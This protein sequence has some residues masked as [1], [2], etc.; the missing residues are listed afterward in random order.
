[1]S[2]M[3]ARSLAQMSAE[4]AKT[5]GLLRRQIQLGFGITSLFSGLG[6]VVILFGCVNE[7]CGLSPNRGEPTL[8]AGIVVEFV[9]ATALL[10]YRTNL[11]ELM[12]ASDRLSDRWQILIAFENAAALPRKKKEA[13]MVKLIFVLAQEYSQNQRRHNRRA[14]IAASNKL[15]AARMLVMRLTGKTESEIGGQ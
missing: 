8:V 2:S 14:T 13:A 1:M 11:Q 3:H 9:S 6:L 7:F 5:F 4:L 15:K 12:S 10:V